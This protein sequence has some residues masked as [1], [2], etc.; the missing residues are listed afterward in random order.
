MKRHLQKKE[1]ALKGF[2]G[3]L[4]R[5]LGEKETNVQTKSKVGNS[6]PKPTQPIFRSVKLIFP[7]KKERCLGFIFV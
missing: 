7:Q 4:G 6:F 2:A 3:V 5:I 1:I